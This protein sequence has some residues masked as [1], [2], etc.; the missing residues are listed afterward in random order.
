MYGQ[1]WGY[2][3]KLI[4]KPA[5]LSEGIASGGGTSIQSTWPER[6]AASRVVASGIGMTTIFWSF[7]IR[8]LSQY[9]S[10][11]LS[12]TNCPGATRVIRNGPVP[13]GCFANS[14]QLRPA[15]SHCVGLTIS[16]FGTI[17]GKKLKGVFV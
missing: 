17:E 3:H 8:V 7:G 6:N 12:S 2:G 11:R 16:M 13:A 1:V 14:V 9:V 10:L 5:A 15:F 4:W